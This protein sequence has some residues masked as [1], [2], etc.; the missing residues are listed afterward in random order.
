MAR[1]E[2]AQYLKFTEPRLRPALDLLAAVPLARAEHIYDLGCGP[3]N[4]A[5]HLR[6]R[7][8]EA[9][10]T[11]VDSSAE[12]LAV[13]RA[14]HPDVTWAEADLAAWAPE[15][16][17][18]ILYSNASLQWL[19]DHGTLF[20][21]LVHCLAPGGVLA[22]QMP[23]NFAS[24]SH[25]L[26]REVAADGPWSG[27]LEGVGPRDPVG[28]PE[29]YYEHLAPHARTIDI[30]ETVYLHAL[31][32]LDP[33]VEWN[34]GTALRPVLAALDDEAERAAFLAEY[35][36]RVRAAYPPRP[37]GRTLFPFRRLFIVAQ[38]A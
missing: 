22:A 33:V 36:G 5:A 12:M 16:P 14:A 30:W 26:I 8:P 29:S 21:H 24:P 3:G 28:A 38:V 7:W 27:R 34:R 35:A 18:D 32:G 2:P 20:Q 19:G 31:E 25:T 17:G 6:A 1:W 23:R 11:G 9:A 15:A 37:D 13:A 4:M 10:I